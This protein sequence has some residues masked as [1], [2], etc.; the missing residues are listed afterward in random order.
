MKGVLYALEK[1]THKKF[2]IPEM[3]HNIISTIFTLICVSKFCDFY[4]LKGLENKFF[5]KQFASDLR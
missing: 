3:Y 2:L 1:K 4:I 5:L